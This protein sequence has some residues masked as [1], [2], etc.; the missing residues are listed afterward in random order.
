MQY[1]A[2]PTILPA[3]GPGILTGSHA[4]GMS[5]QPAIDLG[6]LSANQL[7]R[8]PT[9]YVAD[10]IGS[11]GIDVSWRELAIQKSLDADLTQERR[12]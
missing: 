7:A 10:L 12:R 8:T 1:R 4:P 5:C 9:E 6:S 2:G 3:T 11:L